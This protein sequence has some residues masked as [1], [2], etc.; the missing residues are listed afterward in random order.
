[1]PAAHNDGSPEET[2]QQKQERLQP[3]EEDVTL[4]CRCGLWL[5]STRAR[6]FWS[7]Q[8]ILKLKNKC[9]KNN[10]V[11]KIATDLFVFASILQQLSIT[12]VKVNKVQV[13]G[14]ESMTFA[15]CLDQDEKKI[16]QSVTR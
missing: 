8:N 1:M 7:L 5:L 14:T 16:L 10:A 3:G 11:S 13:C 9:C 2:Q 6:T 4:L 15:V 12:E